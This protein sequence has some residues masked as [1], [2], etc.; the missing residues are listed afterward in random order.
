MFHRFICRGRKGIGIFWDREWGNI[1]SDTY[2]LHILSQ[3]Q[4]YIEEN[5]G[6]IFMQDNAPSH[7]SEK[8]KRNLQR[9]GITCIKWP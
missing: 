2:D 6:L 1:N 3:L 4:A 9:Q 5:P 7:R 8:T